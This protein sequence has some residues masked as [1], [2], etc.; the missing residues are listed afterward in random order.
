MPCEHFNGRPFSHIP[1]SASAIN[2][3]CSAV[4][5]SELELSASDF[6]F[7]ALQNEDGLA[8]SGIPDDSGLVEGPRKDHIA[9]RV[10]V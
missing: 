6:S 3:R 9:I 4:I 7:M 8:D 2:R 10:E 1:E 5:S